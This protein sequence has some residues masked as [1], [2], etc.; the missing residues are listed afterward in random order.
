M[1][2]E[3]ARAALG[4]DNVFQTTTLATIQA[5]GLLSLW[6][7]LADD[8]GDP[9]KSWGCLGLTFKLM[10]KL[11]MHRD[12]KKWNLPE[13]EAIERRRLFWE[14]ES[15]DCWQA[16]GYGRPPSL[17]RPH[18]DTTQPFD[19]EESLGHAPQFFRLV[20]TFHL[21]IRYAYLCGELIRRTVGNTIT[22]QKVS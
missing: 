11:G 7:Q 6:Y 1:Y 3:L 13:E 2:C 4:L 18:F 21:F 14:I 10:Q 8:S 5:L 20:H 22:S 17:V 15:M 16:M 19:T 9:S 12:G